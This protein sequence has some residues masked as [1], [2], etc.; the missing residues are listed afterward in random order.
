MTPQSLL[1]LVRLKLGEL[2]ASSIESRKVQV[3]QDILDLSKLS[4]RNISVRDI[5]YRKMKKGYNC[6]TLAVEIGDAAILELLVKETLIDVDLRDHFGKTALILAA[7]KGRLDLAKIVLEAKAFVNLSDS[8]QN[9]ALILAVKIG[10]V[11]LARELM[12]TY[13]ANV[14]KENKFGDSALSLAFQRLDVDMANMLVSAGADVK[15]RDAKGNTMMMTAVKKGLD[16]MA[17]MV[18][19]F[20]TREDIDIFNKPLI[21]AA[22][23]NQPK[24]VRILLTVFA[25]ANKEFSKTALFHAI[26]G[27]HLETVKVF[28]E[29]G[30]KLDLSDPMDLE[31]FEVA[32]ECGF[33]EVFA[34]ISQNVLED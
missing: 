6:L 22:Q 23:E 16:K 3:I 14:Y 18:L 19:Q 4:L 24:I 34:L 29:F 28:L 15:H 30:S 1:T 33:D 5:F 8:E 25:D 26:L 11:P 31:A 20:D 13:G 10:H 2:F 27:N 12:V 17:D 21:A 9:T 32:Q 7:E